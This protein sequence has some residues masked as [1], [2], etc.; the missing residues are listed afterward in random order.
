MRDHCNHEELWA[1]WV[2]D[3]VR[4]GFAVPTKLVTRAL[5]VLGDAVGVM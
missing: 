3:S 2:L 1:H 4:D 5:W